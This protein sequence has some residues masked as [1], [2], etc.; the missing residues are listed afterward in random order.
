[1]LQRFLRYAALSTALFY[2]ACQPPEEESE[3]P[4]ANGEVLF[5]D[6][7][8]GS[9][10][11]FNKWEPEVC[12]AE[13]NYRLREG[14]LE[15]NVGNG[16]CGLNSRSTYTLDDRT[17]CFEARWKVRERE[18]VTSN[19]SLTEVEPNEGVGLGYLLLPDRLT[20]DNTSSPACSSTSSC[21]TNLGQY[22]ILQVE[23]SQQQASYL[24]DGK[25]VFRSRDCIP[26]SA[27]MR[28]DL[29]CQSVDDEEKV[30]S[31][32]YVRLILE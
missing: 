19:I 13:A 11:D 22:H 6:D 5:E 28:V 30:C 29:S 1:M 20:C 15:L 12:G 27:Q 3:D 25:E 8:D 7:F 10:L 26:H 24:I 32:D 21:A 4:C 31:F 9:E 14:I 17:L 23:A 16:N 2:P 18:G